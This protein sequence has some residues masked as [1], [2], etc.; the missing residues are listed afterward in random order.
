MNS[1]WNERVSIRLCLLNVLLQSTYGSICFR[2][3][4]L[5]YTFVSVVTSSS[6]IETKVTIFIVM[7]RRSA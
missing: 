5:V 1:P 2:S 3:R 7:R 4:Y 6:F